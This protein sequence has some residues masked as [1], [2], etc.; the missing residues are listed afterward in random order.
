MYKKVYTFQTL[1]FKIVTNNKDSYIKQLKHISEFYIP[2]SGEP[3]RTIKMEYVEDINLFNKILEEAKLQKSK[4]YQSFT[5]Q[6]H[7]E[8]QSNNGEKYYIVDNQKN[9]SA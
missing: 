3:L 9:I 1:N 2:Y 8:Y 4:A 7:K 5:N 6:I